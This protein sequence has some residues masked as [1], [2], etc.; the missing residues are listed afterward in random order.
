VIWEALVEIVAEQV[1]LFITEANNQ[2]TLNE[3][4]D[5]DEVLVPC[6]LPLEYFSVL[7]SKLP[8]YACVF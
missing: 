2:Y 6:L 1:W 4:H 5:Q 3:D 7:L 8:S